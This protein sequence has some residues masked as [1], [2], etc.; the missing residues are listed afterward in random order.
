M[1]LKDVLVVAWRAFWANVLSVDSLM[2]LAFILVVAVL[3]GVAMGRTMGYVRY[4]VRAAAAILLVILLIGVLGALGLHW[5]AG[6]G[7][8]ILGWL[9]DLVQAPFLPAG[10]A[11]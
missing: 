1:S 6:G 3:A 8:T 2:V 4:A 11:A 9:N 7:S 10:G 5:D